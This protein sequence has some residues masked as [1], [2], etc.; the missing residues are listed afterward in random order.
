M[1]GGTG[2]L[3]LLE[4]P[5]T[6]AADSREWWLAYRRAG[7][8]SEAATCFAEQRFPPMAENIRSY[9]NARVALL[10]GKATNEQ[11]EVI[12]VNEDRI[13]QG[14]DWIPDLPV[15]AR[16]A[17]MMFEGNASFKWT[18]VSPPA[19]YLAG[20]RTEKYDIWVDKV[21]MADKTE[22]Q[23]LD[24]NQYE[25]RLLGVS[26]TDLAV[27]VADEIEQ[28]TQE[29]KHWSPVGQFEDGQKYPLTVT[30]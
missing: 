24:G 11:L 5:Y 18:F 2:S 21:P 23:S 7:A 19:M 12:R 9:R 27:A 16:A 4:D 15:A 22:R 30:L 28:K 6:T 8:D 20:P 13:L 14:E 10:A 29:G 17:Y 1:I 3:H 25:G 26:A